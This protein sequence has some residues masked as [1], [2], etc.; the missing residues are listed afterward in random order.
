MNENN[1]D[2][3]QVRTI[4]AEPTKKEKVDMGINGKCNVCNSRYCSCPERQ[5]DQSWIPFKEVW[6]EI[7]EKK[8][9][10]RSAFGTCIRDLDE[11]ACDRI[12]NF[13]EKTLRDRDESLIGIVKNAKRIFT[14]DIKQKMISKT[15]VVE[16]FNDIL[17]QLKK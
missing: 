14:S 10:I 4:M 9:V 16:I 1:K 5:P 3:N 12:P 15:F 11:E 8:F 13:I 17:K 7:F 2:P 6:K